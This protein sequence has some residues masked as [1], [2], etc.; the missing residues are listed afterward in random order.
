MPFKR[1]VESSMATD[2]TLF[3]P[4]RSQH[5]GTTSP[6]C[7]VTKQVNAFVPSLA[8]IQPVG[9]STS[10]VALSRSC[11]GSAFKANS[12]SK[13]RE[14]RGTCFG[15]ACLAV[16]CTELLA[17]PTCAKAE[18]EQTAADIIKRPTLI[19]RRMFSLPPFSINWLARNYA[20]SQTL[21]LKSPAH[22]V[23]KLLIGAYTLFF[24]CKGDQFK[25][26]VSRLCGLLA[27]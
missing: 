5:I 4:S 22:G 27:G 14:N 18:V 11:F 12:I 26:R 1:I 6:A 2:I 19:A 7:R 13:S 24:P 15:L 17:L 9:S 20:R 16:P 23:S 8:F 21:A 10:T 25:R 3:A